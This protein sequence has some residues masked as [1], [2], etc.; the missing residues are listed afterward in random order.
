MNQLSATMKGLL[1]AIAMIAVSLGIYFSKK[2][3]DNNLQY[4]TYALYVAG[5][6]W[7]LVSFRRNSPGNPTF[8]SYFGEGFKCFIVVAL[9]MVA[10]TYIFLKLQPSFREDMAV[11]YRAELVKKGNYTPAEI[12]ANVAKAKDYFV[13]MLISMAVFSYLV[14]GALVALITAG[15]LSSQKKTSNA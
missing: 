15:F 10:F 9:L 11:N 4:I 12:D 1:T 5:I 3:F 8:K 14:I 2:N 6:V 13:T 7:T